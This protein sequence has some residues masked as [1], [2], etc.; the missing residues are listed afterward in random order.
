VRKGEG[1]GEKGKEM[2]GEGSVHPLLFYNLTTAYGG[3]E[4]HA[5][6]GGPTAAIQ[7]SQLLDA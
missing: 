4:R 7:A 3:L 1:E 5:D 2:E 6:G